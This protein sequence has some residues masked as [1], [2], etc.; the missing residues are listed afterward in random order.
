MDEATSNL[1]SITEAAIEAMLNSL[2]RE[3]TSIIIAHRLSTIRQCDRIVV[4]EKGKIVEQ[5]T[6]CELIQMQGKY[7]TLWCEQMLFEASNVEGAEEESV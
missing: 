3:M 7:A 1:D 5:G 4:L 2:S 6:H